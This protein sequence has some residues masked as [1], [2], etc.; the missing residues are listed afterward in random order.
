MRQAVYS[1][2]L[3]AMRAIG[4]AISLRFREDEERGPAAKELRKS[5]EEWLAW[6]NDASEAFAHISAEEKAV[7]RAKVCCRLL[8]LFC[9][10]SRVWLQ[11]TSA[12][13]WLNG[14]MA[15]QAAVALTEKPVVLSDDINARRTNL[16]KDGNAVRSKPKVS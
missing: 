16:D 13:E 11:A 12:L 5:V 8:L 6:C 2:R 9:C 10:V 14:E 7:L 3:A 4:D 1:A 15:K